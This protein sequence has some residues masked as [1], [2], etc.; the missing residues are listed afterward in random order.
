MRKRIRQLARGKF[1]YDKP[2]LS[3]LEKE[4]E[5]VVVEG[6]ELSGSFT[7]ASTSH[8][9]IRGVV[10]STSPR[11][12]CLTPQFEGEEVRI[13]YQ[14]HSR[15]LVE[16]DVEKG[17]FMIV[18][19]Q[20]EHSLSFC[21]SVSKLYA[22]TSAGP[23]KTLQ[24]FACLAREKWDEAYQ[25]FYHKGF[26]N[27]I[28]ARETRES[29]LYRGI[30]TAKPSMQ[31]M[32]EFLIG[33][34]RK[35][36]IHFGIDQTIC[37]LPEVT[38]TS[39]QMVE[40][41]KDEWGYIA[42]GISADADF[43]RL[44]DE[45]ITTDDFLGS[46]YSYRYLIDYD[47]MHGGWNFGRISFSTV[48]ETKTIE[49]AAH[50]GE[51]SEGTESVRTQIKECKAGITELYQAYRLKRVV[52][53]VWANETIDI[54]NHLHALEP[55]EPMY[56]LM[57]A[58]A[59]Q[60]NR[61]RQEAEWILED[62]RREWPDRKSPVWGYYLYIMTLMERE[63]T[64]VDRMT[65]EI[66]LIFH[67]NPDSVLLFW[68]LTFLKEEYYNNNA[69]KL[70]AI[71]Y[72]VMRGNNSP[73]LYLEAYYLY[74]QDPYL[75]RKLGK[76][77][78]RILRWAMR[79]QAL[80]K[81]LAAQIFQIVEMNQGFDE[82][83]YQL[84]TVAYEVD[85]K[86]EY[87]G[88]ICSYLIRAQRFDKQYHHWFEM[89]IELEL[90]I[91]RLYEA[92]LLSF[93]E[94]GV[95][96]VPKIIQMYFQYDSSLPYRKMA[97]LYNNI[98]ADKENN[99]EVYDK[100]RRTMGRFAMEQV[101]QEH[102]DDN[103]AVLYEEMLDLGFVNEE[104]AHSLAHILF[105]HKLV[106]FDTRMVRAIIYQRQL[107][108]PQIVPIVEQAAYFQLYSQDYV[109]LFEDEKGRRYAGSVSY[110]LQ[111]LMNQGRYLAKC[112]ALAPEE[113]PYLIAH[114]DKRED[115]LLFEPEDKKF[116][117]RMLFAKEL[118]PEYQS[119]MAMEILRYL[120]TKQQKEDCTQYLEQAD[121]AQMP[122]EVRRY[123][124]DMLVENHRY[125]LAYELIQVYGM[126]QIGSAAKVALASYRIGGLNGEEDSGDEYLLLL[127][128][129]VFFHKKYNDG[130]LGYLCRFY[131]GPTER[132]CTL[133]RAARQ[134]EINTF[135]LEE[136]I[137][138]QML[139]SDH[140]LQGTEELFEHYY[141][142]GGRD[143]VILAYLSASAQAYVVGEVPMRQELLELIKARYV[144]HQE[145]N[146]A[147]KLALLK[148]M[149]EREE[150]ADVSVEDALLGEYMCR[151]ISFG[152]F[153]K[154]DRSLVQK[155]HLYD[156]MFLEYRTN[157]RSHVVL[158]YSRDEDGENF[159]T[160]DMVDMYGGIFVKQFVMFF[161]ESVQYYIT[162]ERGNQVEVTESSR[163]NS[164]DVY[165]DWDESRYGLLNQML[166]SSTLQDD[167]SLYQNMKQYEG[168][169]EVT[170]QVFRIL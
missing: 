135:E 48:Y 125:D 65:K 9:P 29:M 120:Q 1:E 20:S 45:T 119:R 136:R 26:S 170:R 122:Q 72:W 16:G 98:I 115:H 141:N 4:L 61:Q 27:I 60:I 38:E 30:V 73:Y 91:T 54:L 114:F 51:L 169:D 157:P 64:Y 46:T 74:C 162:E 155:Y 163:M 42:I 33:I 158:H 14:F 90:R 44:P 148:S 101:E 22:E 128:S 138:V 83:Q 111:S 15:G 88:I 146:D 71:E 140:S 67:E 34:G 86:P 40:I 159:V 129:D 32:E 10:Y 79:R 149:A 11:M 107:K 147:C 104:I 108:E 58:Q 24:D 52:T 95:A 41:K 87:V 8:V 109:I 99:P 110:R 150:T 69:H 53:G 37:R 145:L 143:V 57:K 13:R 59:L 103:L 31:N 94:R 97:I 39:Q 151:N 80:N 130:M 137:L 142:A 25:L 100:Y 77:E 133:W 35:N 160:E 43:I 62:F 102:M 156:K 93:D 116:F 105:M 84:L 2:S 28:G 153:R 23:I 161:G 165:A 92:Y 164:N 49:V 5:L 12:E 6:Q 85:P 50:K 132:M 154:L 3:I 139:Y 167:M 168:F 117:S 166:I 113:L 89:G 70:K 78:I 7:I 126:D 19:N 55:E 131:S 82:V 56:L 75:L 76:F 47:R 127:V 66:E 106:V 68:I 118:N 112:M 134:F 121:F 17:S 123:M 152:F 21:V 81:E 124:L 144:S 18:C 96:P 63:P 36:P